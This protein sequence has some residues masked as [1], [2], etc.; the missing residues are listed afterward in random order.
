M[1]FN[2]GPWSEFMSVTIFLPPGSLFWIL[3]R[4]RSVA[5]GVPGMERRR[6]IKIGLSFFNIL[7]FVLSF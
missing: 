1:F 4:D 7:D 2:I 6:K 5:A 3:T